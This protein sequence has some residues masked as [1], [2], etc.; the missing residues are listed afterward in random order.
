MLDSKRD[1]SKYG[2]EREVGEVMLKVI[3]AVLE[4]DAGVEMVRLVMLIGHIE[5][6]GKTFCLAIR[7]KLFD[8]CE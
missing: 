3:S 5:G 4:E 8:A 1:V 6:V 7:L 2:C